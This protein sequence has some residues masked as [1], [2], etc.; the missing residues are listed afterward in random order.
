MGSNPLKRNGNYPYVPQFFTDLFACK[1]FVQDYKAQWAAVKDTIVTHAWGECMKYVDQLRASGAIDREMK[2]WPLAG[3]K[4][5]TE[6]EKMR[7]WLQNRLTHI[8]YL[9]A[10]IPE[11]K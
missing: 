6:L 11:P 8:S 3:K 5:D 4:F 7:K 10:A 9:I 1:E 2:R